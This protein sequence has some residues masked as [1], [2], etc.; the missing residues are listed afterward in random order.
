VER[1]R[2]LSIAKNARQGETR[3]AANVSSRWLFSKSLRIVITAES[4]K[5]G[6]MIGRVEPES[7]EADLFRGI[8]GALF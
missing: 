1:T 8:P 2:Q 3:V 4:P 7:R 6:K 5:R